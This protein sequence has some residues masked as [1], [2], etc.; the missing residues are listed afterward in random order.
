M[1][2][3]YLSILTSTAY[4]APKIWRAAVGQYKV[5]WFQ[6]WKTDYA[7]GL[8]FDGQA[9]PSYVEGHSFFSKRISDSTVEKTLCII[10]L[11]ALG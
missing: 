1:K 9:H 7:K 8:S 2:H 5:K 6:F 11:I 4:S 10:Q 3:F